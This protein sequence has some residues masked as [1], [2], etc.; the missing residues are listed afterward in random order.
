[1]LAGVETVH[2]LLLGLPLPLLHSLQGGG[3]PV[4]VPDPSLTSHVPL[5]FPN[6]L[7][8]GRS[9]DSEGVLL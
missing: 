4:A 2:H 3:R 8:S 1:M 5:P 6:Q 9:R 7:S